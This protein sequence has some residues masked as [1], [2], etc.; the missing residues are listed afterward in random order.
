MHLQG[1]GGWVGVECDL[2]L[3]SCGGLRHKELRGLISEPSLCLPSARVPPWPSLTM[4][5]P[6]YHSIPG[7]SRLATLE[8]QALGLIPEGGN[9]R[10]RGG[11][12]VCHSQI[13]EHLQMGACPSLYEMSGPGSGLTPPSKL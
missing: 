6:M 13:L 5:L 3:G 2:C 9:P 8:P 11:A 4:A 1:I 12:H 10:H 7:N